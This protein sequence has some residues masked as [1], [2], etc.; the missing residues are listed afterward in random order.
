MFD[1]EQVKHKTAPSSGQLEMLPVMLAGLLSYCS[2]T[3]GS[4]NCISMPGRSDLALPS[5]SNHKMY[6]QDSQLS[7]PLDELISQRLT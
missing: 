3:C 5:M 2:P 1:E 6:L 7:Y 4:C